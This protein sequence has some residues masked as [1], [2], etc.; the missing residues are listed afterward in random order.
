MADI[1]QVIILRVLTPMLQRK[2]LLQSSGEKELGP[3]IG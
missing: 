2:M 1:V 3:V